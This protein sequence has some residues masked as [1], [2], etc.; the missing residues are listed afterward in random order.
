MAVRKKL[1]CIFDLD[2]TLADTK[3][4]ILKALNYVLRETESSEIKKEDEDKIIGPPIKDS[5]IKYYG[6]TEEQA[7]KG[8]ELYREIYIK[9]FIGESMLYDGLIDILYNLKRASFTIG[10][11]TMKT[12]PQVDAF[13]RIFEIK[14]YFDVIKTA[15][16]SGEVTKTMM[17]NEIKSIYV[18]HCDE[19]FMIGDT[20]GDYAAAQN[21][22]YTFVAADY[23]YGDM[24]N[25]N[26][27]HISKLS[28]ILKII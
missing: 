22:G 25:I 14:D 7:Q 2:G 18:D 13:L 16:P 20:L 11:A 19:F 28:D 3:P 27:L 8:T 21:A 5:L 26:C 10:I 1:V 17:L 24:S 15:V 4:G 9:R 23:G 6:F 12:R